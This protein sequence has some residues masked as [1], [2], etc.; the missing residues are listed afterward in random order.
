[1]T[2]RRKQGKKI[3][4]NEESL[5]ER[6]MKLNDFLPKNTQV[7][8]LSLL[9]PFQKNI[10]YLIISLFLGRAILVSVSVLF[11]ILFQIYLMIQAEFSEINSIQRKVR[12]CTEKNKSNSVM[13]RFGIHFTLKFP[14]IFEFFSKYAKTFFLFIEGDF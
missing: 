3:K 13:W 4:R 14:I 9:F 8:Q 5:E 2:K 12:S 11:I 10:F 6:K 1:M 7:C